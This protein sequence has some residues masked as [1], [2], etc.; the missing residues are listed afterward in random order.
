MIE[1]N[2]GFKSC[3]IIDGSAYYSDRWREAIALILGSIGAGSEFKQT[4]AQVSGTLDNI[5]NR[6]ESRYHGLHI[7]FYMYR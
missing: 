1:W 4:A 6:I 7:Q 2:A 5:L 3:K